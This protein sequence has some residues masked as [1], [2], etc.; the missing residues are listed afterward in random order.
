MN[1]EGEARP[2]RFFLAGPWITFMQWCGD[3]GGGAGVMG[4]GC[5]LS[6]R[7]FCEA[8]LGTGQLAQF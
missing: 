5:L 1:S 2:W 8:I 3:R 4:A 7:S 6:P